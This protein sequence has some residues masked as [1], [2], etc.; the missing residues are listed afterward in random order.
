MTL[1][2]FQLY[3][4]LFLHVTQPSFMSI[5]FKVAWQNAY[6]GFFLAYLHT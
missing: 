2:G 3:I 5:F 1:K 6:F 4:V